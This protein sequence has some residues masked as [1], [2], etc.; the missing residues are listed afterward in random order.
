MVHHL[1]N[2][3]ILFRESKELMRL[4]E[5]QDLERRFLTIPF[6]TFFLKNKMKNIQ[7]INWSC[8]WRS[9]RRQWRSWSSFWEQNQNRTP[10]WVRESLSLRSQSLEMR[11]RRLSME[12][13][14]RRL[15]TLPPY[16]DQ[17]KLTWLLK[18]S[19]ICKYF[20]LFVS[21]QLCLKSL[22]NKKWNECNQTMYI[23]ERAKCG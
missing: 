19:Q 23:W 22:L 12:N 14:W 5:T 10:S 17:N 4:V 16:L 15:E 18:S 13:T 8:R 2:N 9:W 20:C 3:S 7:Q 6:F 21:K 11:R 1:K